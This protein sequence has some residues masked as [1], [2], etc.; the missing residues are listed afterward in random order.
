MQIK[1]LFTLLLKTELPYD[2]AIN[3]SNGL[4][5]GNKENN[6]NNNSNSGGKRSKKKLIK[7]K[8]EN[9][10]KSKKIRRNSI[11]KIRLDLLTLIIR[12]I[13]NQL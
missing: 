7:L 6:S 5:I 10:A 8:S 13:F 3:N 4:W 2:K 9:L 1:A 11:I 12:K